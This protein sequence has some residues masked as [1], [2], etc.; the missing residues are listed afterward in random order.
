MLN[1]IE[2]SFYLPADAADFFNTLQTQ[3]VKYN[4]NITNRRV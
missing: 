2:S 3:T 4:K 1:E